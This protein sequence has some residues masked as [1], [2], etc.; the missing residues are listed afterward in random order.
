[1]ANGHRKLAAA[2]GCVCFVW[3]A[4]AC[5]DE[6][7]AFTV[8]LAIQFGMTATDLGKAKSETTRIFEAAGIAISWESVSA[9]I[10]SGPSVTIS[11]AAHPGESMTMVHGGPKRALA[12]TSPSASRIFVFCARIASLAARSGEPFHA[13]L[14]RVMAHEVGH[15]LLPG[16][17][18]SRTGVMAGRVDY[19]SEQP[20]LFSDEESA[21]IRGSI[22]R[23]R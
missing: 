19:R 14:G 10:S 1:M 12:I 4:P 18:H 20:P 17:P 9:P 15:L 22:A 2:V 11:L 8:K 6:R 3:V 5:A 13:I 23:S 21:L 16:R 7:P